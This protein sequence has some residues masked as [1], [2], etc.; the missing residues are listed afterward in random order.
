M[1]RR[2][3]HPG[4]LGCLA[5]LC[6][7]AGCPAPRP[8]GPGLGQTFDTPEALIQAMR[9]DLARLESL[10]AAG[11]VDMR[12][13]GQ[14]VRAHVL[15]LAARPAWLR[16]ET[17]SFFDAPLSILVSDGE[18]FTVWDMDQGRVLTGRASPV[19]LGRVLPVALDGS[20]LAALLL[21]EPPWIAHAAA[22]LEGGG[23]D[24]YR[25]TLSNDREL[26]TIEVDPA[27][28]R[29][30]RVELVAGGRRR[31]LVEYGDW[32]VRA[33]LP[34]APERLTLEMPEQEMHLKIRLKEIE[35][36]PTLDRALFSLTLP[37]GT[38]AEDLDDPSLDSPIP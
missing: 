11:S 29:P 17:E 28:L 23:R 4:P 6:A 31:V 33:G 9:A 20:A 7:L 36:N 2:R 1:T 30:T 21:G 32:Q 5:L 22:S 18:R 38:Q 25:L 12:Q 14:R 10:R 8:A 35:A 15:Y 34:V 19:N 13:G 16:F 26:Q 37:E 3:A 24:P 27:L